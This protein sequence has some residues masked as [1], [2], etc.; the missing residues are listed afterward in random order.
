MSETIVDKLNIIQSSKV[1]IKEALENKGRT[2]T[3][4]IRTY[5]NEIDNIRSN[6]KLFESVELMNLDADK[7][8]NDM[9][10]VY[11]SSIGNLTADTEFQVAT[12]PE[13]VTLSSAISGYIEVGFV[14]VDTS[15][16]L[17]CMG[18]IRSNMFSLSVYGNDGEYR[19]QYTSSDGINYT[20]TRLEGPSRN[21]R[22]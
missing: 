9:A 3:E 21:G 10:V 7:Q 1:N 18:N 20:R 12:F 15:Q 4:D 5:A 2:P 22:W 14:P 8:E 13:T 17:D 6:I 19:I 11:Y 16:Y